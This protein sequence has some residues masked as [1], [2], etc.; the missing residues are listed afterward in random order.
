MNKVSAEINY[1]SL[2][3]VKSKKKKGKGKKSRKNG[4]IFFQFI[5]PQAHVIKE[6][7]TVV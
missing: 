6:V 4:N 5:S 1:H 3:E 7:I 2:Q